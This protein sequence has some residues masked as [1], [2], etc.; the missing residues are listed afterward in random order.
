MDL[1]RV[2]LVVLSACQTG[3][4]EIDSEG[5]YG[6]QRG[7]KKAGVGAYITSLWKVDDEA[8]SIWMSIFY[9]NLRSGASFANAFYGAQEEL[10]QVQDG[11]FNKP[12]FWASFIMVDGR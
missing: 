3:L 4:G 2:K 7:L 5:V 10:R 11:K 1:S 9:R 12:Y 8:T 6:L